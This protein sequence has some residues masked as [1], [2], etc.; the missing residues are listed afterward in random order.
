M[1]ISRDTAM[2]FV[3]DYW[4]K[5]GYVCGE[6]Q[7]LREYRD[8]HGEKGRAIYETHQECTI[9]DQNGDPFECLAWKTENA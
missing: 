1:T 8:N 9:L 3:Q 5:D 7:Y 6:C 2:T 4:D